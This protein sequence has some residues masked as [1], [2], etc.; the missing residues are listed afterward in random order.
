MLIGHKV[1]AFLVA[2]FL[3]NAANATELP[4]VDFSQFTPEQRKAALRQLNEQTC[5]CGCALTLAQCRINDTT[6]DVSLG[7]ANRVVEKII[8]GE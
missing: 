8:A 7:L 3:A 2:A 5:T 6:C 1:I 4:G